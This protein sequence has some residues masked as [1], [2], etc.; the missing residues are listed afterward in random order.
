MSR[1]ATLNTGGPDIYNIQVWFWR[2][3]V[4]KY[5]H[6][7]ARCRFQEAG[8]GGGYYAEPYYAEEFYVDATVALVAAGA[9]LTALSGADKEGRPPNLGEELERELRT[10]PELHARAEAFR[11]VYNKLRHFGPIHYPEVEDLLENM[12]QRLS[13]YLRTVQDVWCHY[14]R[15]RN[16]TVGRAFTVRF[17]LLE[18]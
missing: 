11:Q 16:A 10:Q 9:S 3:A 12:E 13:E 6:I 2:A 15:K 4:E 5:Y 18:D 8:Y 17:D 7:A 14:L 1:F